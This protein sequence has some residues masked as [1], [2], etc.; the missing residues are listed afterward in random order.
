MNKKEVEF[1]LQELNF[2]EREVRQKFIETTPSGLYGGKDVDG[3][4]V[5][6]MVQQGEE[7]SIRYLNGKGWYEGYVYDKMGFRESEILEKAR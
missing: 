1:T 2:E 3:R 4:Q 7:M 6:V 5:V